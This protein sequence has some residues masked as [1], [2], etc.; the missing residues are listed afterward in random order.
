MLYFIR[1]ADGFTVTASLSTSTPT[2]TQ[3]PGARHL[4]AI[5]L[6]DGQTILLVDE[7]P[8][9]TPPFD[10]RTSRYYTYHVPLL[11]SNLQKAIRRKARNA[12]LRTA[13]W[14]LCREPTELLRRLPVIICE[15][16]Q[17]EEHT[18]LELVW[19]MAATSKGYRLLW[20]D[21]AWVMS[22]VATA[23]ETTGHWNLEEP[24]PS[25][26][27]GALM[28]H[29]NTLA[30][31]LHIRIAFGGMKGDQA[32]LGRLRDRVI[33]GTLPLWTGPPVWLEEDIPWLE[34]EEDILLEAVD[35][36]VYP[37]L[38]TMIPG[39]RLDAVWWCQSAVNV[40]EY[41]G[42]GAAEAET[43]SEER[44]ASLLPNLEEHR[45]ALD[46]F[47]RRMRR[48][49]ERKPAEE[50]VEEMRAATVATVSTLDRWLSASKKK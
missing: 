12:A 27:A 5:R 26:P 48:R 3:R 42:E 50:E 38:D 33:A 44:Y 45:L 37:R 10:V 47:S 36:H 1:K 15:D 39:L 34:P 43:Y 2:S 16:T 9:T 25:L 23:L 13:W 28:R 32:F 6:H 31:A 19:L 46:L 24:G 22:A 11:K 20:S 30:L 14:L 35:Q 4:P 29:P 49:C 18:F 7:R 21:A 8:P 40:R 41:V 17:I